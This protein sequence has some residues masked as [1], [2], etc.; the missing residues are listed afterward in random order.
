[1]LQ[2]FGLTLFTKILLIESLHQCWVVLKIREKYPPVIILGILTFTCQL[3]KNSLTNLKKSP[4]QKNTKFANTFHENHWFFKFKIFQRRRIG[5]FF[6]SAT[7]KKPQPAVLQK[8]KEPPNN[9]LCTLNQIFIAVA[10]FGNQLANVLGR[11]SGQ[12]CFAVQFSLTF[13]F[14]AIFSKFLHPQNWKK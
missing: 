10:N 2:K 1:M 5:W 9:G 7:L 14:F 11:S 13:W 6:E 8:L 4:R 3:Y 12:I